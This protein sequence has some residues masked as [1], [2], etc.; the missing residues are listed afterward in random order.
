MIAIVP[1]SALAAAQAYIKA[2]MMTEEEMD[3]LVT[4][5]YTEVVNSTTCEIGQVGVVHIAARKQ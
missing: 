4:E 5:L 1:L 2:D 3:R